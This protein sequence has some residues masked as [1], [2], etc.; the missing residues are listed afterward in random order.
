MPIFRS[1]AVEEAP[2]DMPMVINEHLKIRD[3]NTLSLIEN[4]K[5]TKSV[6]TK[7]LD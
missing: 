1:G 2:S 5:T 4:G 6:L 3:P 7:G